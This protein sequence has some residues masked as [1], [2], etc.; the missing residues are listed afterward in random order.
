MLA[1]TLITALFTPS[2]WMDTFRFFGKLLSGQGIISEW[3]EG[4]S[5][6]KSI[7]HQIW[8]F[9]KIGLFWIP[10]ACALQVKVGLFTCEP[11]L[12]IVK[13]IGE[14]EWYECHVSRFVYVYAE[15]LVVMF[16]KDGISMNVVHQM[17]HNIWYDHHKVVSSR[18]MSSYVL[19]Q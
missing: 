9:A 2:G 7:R 10:L 16:V 17:F 6:R 18:C 15:F 5:V 13:V 8:Y 19:L 14:G 4:K 12:E 1:K 3:D 11:L